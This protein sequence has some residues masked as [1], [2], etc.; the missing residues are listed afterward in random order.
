MYI[1]L[2]F[3]HRS[4]L[5]RTSRICRLITFEKAKHCMLLAWMSRDKS[6]P[7]RSCLL[8][9]AHANRSITAP[10]ERLRNYSNLNLT[11]YNRS[12]VCIGQLKMF[13]HGFFC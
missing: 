3:F 5:V 8:S 4:N 1:Y 7:K 13:G 2:G 11:N 6:S 10:K 12:E 9:S